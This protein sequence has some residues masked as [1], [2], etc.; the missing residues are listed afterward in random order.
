MTSSDRSI[1][2]GYRLAKERFA[3]LGVDT[4]TVIEKLNAIP[5]SIQCWQGDDVL[6]FESPN[7]SLTGGIQTT[8]SYIGRARNAPE[9]RAD[10]SSTVTH[11]G[12]ETG[13]SARYL[14][15]SQ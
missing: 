4:D 2:S 9:L 1:E 8:G 6:G 13:E 15:R 12:Q 3:E 7:G 10:G 14:S 5:I 11:P